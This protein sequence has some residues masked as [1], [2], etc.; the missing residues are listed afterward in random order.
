MSFE[1]PWTSQMLPTVNSLMYEDALKAAQYG[2]ARLIRSAASFQ[3]FSSVS[4]AE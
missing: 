1:Y 2:L 3:C 4:L